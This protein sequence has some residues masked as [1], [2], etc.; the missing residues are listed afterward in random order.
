MPQKKANEEKVKPS[1]KVNFKKQS[2]SFSWPKG[3]TFWFRYS[4]DSHLKKQELKQLISLIAKSGVD[5]LHWV[6]TTGPRP[7]I[8]I[9]TKNSWFPP[10]EFSIGEIKFERWN[11]SFLKK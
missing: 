6:F 10:L 9:A 3:K 1:S 7:G 5:I 8:K 11:L 4:E 2:W